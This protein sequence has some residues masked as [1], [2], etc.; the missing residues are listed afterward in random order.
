M[1]LLWGWSLV[2]RDA[3]VVDPWWSIGFLLVTLNTVRLSG[4]GPGKALLVG[5]VALWALRLWG[6]LIWRARGKPEDARYTAFRQRFGPDRY[7]W[8]S[9]FQVFLLQGTLV[10]LV[11]APLQAAAAA[12]SDDPVHPLDLVGAALALFG[13]GYEA[14]ADAQLA[15]WKRRPDRGEVMDQGLWRTSRHPNY[16]GEILVAWGFWCFAASEPAALGVLYAPVLMTWLLVRVSGV[17]ML[18]AHM[19]ARK[20]AYRAYMERTPALVPGR[21]R[22]SASPPEEPPRPAPPH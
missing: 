6:Y 18:D 9:L 19:A 11:S 21:P 16:F 22:P 17:A 5:V 2:R 12:A 4:F 8:V 7:G 1:L 14:V 15:A 10:L 3:S 13:A 20:P